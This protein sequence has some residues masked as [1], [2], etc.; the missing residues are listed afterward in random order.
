MNTFYRLKIFTAILILVTYLFSTVAF[1]AEDGDKTGTGTVNKESSSD[2]VSSDD[3]IT[4][5]DIT[6]WSILGGTPAIVF[7]FGLKTWD[8]GDRHSP[9]SEKEG[10]FGEDTSFGGADKAGHL[11]AHYMV[12]RAVYNIFDWTESGESQKWA[13]SI[14]TTMGVGLLIEVG[15]AYTSEYGFSY[16]DLVIDY[17]GILIGAALDYFPKVDALFGLSIEYIPSKGYRDGYDKNE[18]LKYALDIVNDYTGMQYMVNFKPA[19]FQNLG[20]DVP[21]ALRLISID[22]GFYTK[23][24]THYDVGEFAHKHE[25]DVFV[26]ISVNSAQLLTELWSEKHR[27]AA[28]TMSH[29]FLEY[30]HL[31]YDRLPIPTRYTNDLNE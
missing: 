22:M 27:N 8:W 18:R 19:G 26:G 9:K 11:F 10:W 3:G 30:Y 28:Y 21:L 1:S 5:R 14:G 4:S 25:R 12:Q 6:R 20:F 23:G 15:D 16:E 17:T 24:Y 13:Y 29:T 2:G 7:L 31:P